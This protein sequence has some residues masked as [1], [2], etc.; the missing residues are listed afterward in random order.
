VRRTRKDGTVVYFSDVQ[1]QPLLA[2][3]QSGLLSDLGER[4]VFGDIDE[5]LGAARKYLA[6]EEE[7]KVGKR[8]P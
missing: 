1:A 8:S 6:L 4:N 7:G 5:A 2:L 3:S